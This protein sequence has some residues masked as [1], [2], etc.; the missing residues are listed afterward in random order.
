[1][2]RQIAFLLVG[3][4]LMVGADASAQVKAGL[5]EIN[6]SASLQGLKAEGS[7]TFTVATFS[8]ALDSEFQLTLSPG[9]RVTGRPRRFEFTLGGGSAQVTAESFSGDVIISRRGGSRR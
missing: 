9:Q 1:M 6:G 7:E 8:G 4:S 3:L 5:N 2:F